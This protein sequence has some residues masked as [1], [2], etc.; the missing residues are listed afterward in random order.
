MKKVWLIGINLILIAA[1]AFV[2]LRD[3]QASPTGLAVAQIEK[4]RAGYIIFLNVT[5]LETGE[6]F[7][8]NVK[9]REVY[10]SKEGAQFEKERLI[11]IDSKKVIVDID[12]DAKACSRQE[13]DVTRYFYDKNG[14]GQ[15]DQDE[16]IV[17]GTKTDANGCVAADLPDE[18]YKIVL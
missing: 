3:E 7:K 9:E 6:T 14:N 11:A 10:F 8:E 5:D 1:I 4:V 12:G 2:A 16:I 13:Y 15:R 18:T 17:Y